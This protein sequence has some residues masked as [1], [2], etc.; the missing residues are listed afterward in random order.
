MELDRSF[1]GEVYL[2]MT[3]YSV[4]PPPITRRPSKLAPKDRLSR[5]PVT[6]PKER[7]SPY[8]SPQ[9]A[10]A[11]GTGH[12]LRSSQPTDSSAVLPSVRPPSA[13]HSPLDLPPSLQV[14]K[15]H[16]Q[17][18]SPPSLP[19]VPKQTAIPG[20]YQAAHDTP[21]RSP[22]SFHFPG[23]ELPPR[24]TAGSTAP[25]NPSPS[26]L[27]PPKFQDPTLKNIPFLDVGPPLKAEVTSPKPLQ[28]IPSVLRPTH[29]KSSPIPVQSRVPPQLP[30][31]QSEDPRE[32]FR[33]QLEESDAEFA[34]KLA[35]SEGLD[36]ER[37]RM[38]EEDA[39]LAR[40]L[41]AEEG[42]DETHI[43]GGW[44]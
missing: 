27:P 34:A 15:I 8:L 3:Y 6:P 39:E 33:R 25:A 21:L 19:H 9:N 16:P 31:R 29:V 37:L 42:G 13:T 4:E 24:A 12:P 5:P 10:S 30:P 11:V 26:P 40:R 14:P 32:L 17:R 38:E 44:Q 43:P 35:Q 2:E 20:H 28:H 36:L 18:Q 22:P 23:P 7:T 41:A 1:R